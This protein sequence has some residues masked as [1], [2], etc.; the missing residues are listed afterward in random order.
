MKEEGLC[1]YP[2]KVEDSF[3]P[4]PCHKLPSIA[5]LCF[6]FHSHVQ[7]CLQAGESQKLMEAVDVGSRGASIAWASIA[8]VEQWP[9]GDF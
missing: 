8:D 5:G 2:E 7:R 6:G 4:D 1:W 9:L 3:W